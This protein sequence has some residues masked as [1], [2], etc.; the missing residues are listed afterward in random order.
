[1]QLGSGIAV[2]VMQAGS[3]SSDWIPSQRTSICHG[4]ALKRQNKTKQKGTA[5]GSAIFHFDTLE[6]TG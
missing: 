6:A 5:L 2:A 3:Y 1:M 4:S